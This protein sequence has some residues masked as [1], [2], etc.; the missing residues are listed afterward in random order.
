MHWSE[1]TLQLIRAARDE[2][3]DA[4][5]DVTAALVAQPD[6]PVAARIVARAAGIMAGQ[7][8]GPLICTEFSASLGTRI[9]FEPVEESRDGTEIKA[10]Q[11]VAV[12]RG[13]RQAVL[14]A[15]RTLLNFL[16][17]TCGVATLTR[18]YVDAAR[19]ANPH[20]QVLDTRKTMPG[21]R[22]IDKYAVRCGGGS[23]HRFG[24]YD[25][26]LIKDNHLAGVPLAELQA[27]VTN[28]LAR[29]R[30]EW[31]RMS[32]V[33]VEVDSLAQMGEI[34]KIPGVDTILL[35]NF[36]VDQLREAVTLRNQLGLQMRMK[37]EA[38]GGVSL[39]TI[40]AIAATGV[41]R[42]SVGAITHSATALDLGLDF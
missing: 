6:K 14:T 35:D 8:L 42:I 39:E 20:V 38:S 1:R 3:L 23:N 17:R 7:S 22:E 2:D 25:A 32:F 15:E 12:V 24:L 4:N 19:S 34:A 30:P 18:R 31:G 40:A 26:I 21:W 37:L 33:E 11:A 41:D 28:M 13:G 10:S 9:C 29:I 5:G 16:C 27:C 36:N